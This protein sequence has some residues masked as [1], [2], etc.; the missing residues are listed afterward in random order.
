MGLGIFYNWIFEGHPYGHLP[1][2]RISSIDRIT[3]E[4]VQDFFYTNYIREASRIG[5]SLMMSNPK[6]KLKEEMIE[7][8]S[9]GED[10][11]EV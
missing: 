10:I 5:V 6:Q 8:I 2:G 7:R 4:D 3:L 9:S 11:P 1:S